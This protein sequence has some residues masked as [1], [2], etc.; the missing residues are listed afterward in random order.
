MAAFDF[1]VRLTVLSPPALRFIHFEDSFFVLLRHRITFE[2]W[3]RLNHFPNGVIYACRFRSCAGP[4]PS[5]PK[6]SLV[7]YLDLRKVLRA[8]LCI[9]APFF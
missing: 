5:A 7:A 9:R 2:T 3:R 6:P 4:S 8:L 1:L